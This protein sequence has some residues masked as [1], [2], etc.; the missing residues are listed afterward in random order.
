[1]PDRFALGRLPADPSKPKL[2]LRRKA[3]RQLDV[4]PSAD[5]LSAVS[6]W[7]MLA[8]D[9]VGDCTMAAAA[10]IAIAVDK[11]GQDNDLQ[12]TDEQ[13]L[14]AYSAVSGYDPARPET[15]VGATLQDACDY[16]HKI[17]IS[18]NKITAF[19][20]IDPKDLNLIRSA[21]AVF[22]SVYVGMWVTQEA[23]DQ[24][25]H[26]QPWTTTNRRSRQLGGHC[27]QLGSYDAD[28]FTAVTWGQT[29]KLSVAFQKRWIDEIVVPIDLDWLRKT[30]TS[31]AGLDVAQL[32]SDYESLTGQPGPFEEIIPP[33][34]PQPEPA[35]DP[36]GDLIKAFETWRSVKGR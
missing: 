25:D 27:I 33:P 34:A 32:N 20:W 26:G 15:D 21:I 30:G 31:P 7:G 1:L 12:I 6:Q 8:N 18:G 4:Q 17:G 13:V 3:Q 11:Y 9:R 35:P 24:F 36:D 19:A 5:W 10:H 28:T 22:G 23:M 16:W 29:Q 14:E 2:R